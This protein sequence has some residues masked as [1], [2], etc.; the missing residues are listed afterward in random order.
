MIKSEFNI[1]TK[2]GILGGG[3]LG[4]MLSQAAISYGLELAILDP[5]PNAPARRFTSKFTLGSFQDEETVFNFGKDLEV[6]TIEIEQVNLQA[7]VRLESLGVQVHPSSKVVGLI[8]DKGIQKQ[9][10]VDSEFPTA[11]FQYLATKLD[12]PKEA[13][14]FPVMLK[15]RVGGYDG[16]GVK[17][18]RNLVDSKEVLAS[19]FFMGACIIEEIADFDKEISVIVAR[20]RFG[21][22]VSYDPVEME[23]NPVAN[24]VEFLRA[25]ACISSE[26]AQKAKNLAEKI[27]ERL[28]M[29]GILAVEMFILKN[30]S[31]WV[32]EMA[33]RPHNSGHHTIEA[34]MTSQFDQHL[35]AILDLPLGDASTR[36]PSVMMNVLG[37]AGYTGKARYIGFQ[38]VL[39]HSGVFV[40]LYGKDQ[41]KPMRKMGHITLLDFE[42]GAYENA[43]IIQKSIKVIS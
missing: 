2:V 11:P 7:L 38:E 20:N 13:A 23:F 6:L 3:Q 30:G 32:N 14:T 35:R 16:K 10:L 42:G 34:C 25:P 40:H 26:T 33:P 41:T 37:E 21:E 24:L 17:A 5:D 4:L 28:N 18:I 43:Q 8:Q 36:V 27:I 12:L 15:A 9:F 19:P 1:N 22:I 29:V 39:A 31:L